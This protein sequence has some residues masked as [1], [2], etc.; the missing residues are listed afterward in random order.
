MQFLDG[1]EAFSVGMFVQ[2]LGW[3]VEQVHL[4]LA[5]VRRDA[6]KKSVHMHHWL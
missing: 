1:L 6:M 5:H 4:F 2:V 3:T